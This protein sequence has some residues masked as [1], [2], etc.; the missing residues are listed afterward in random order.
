MKFRRKPKNAGAHLQL[1][2]MEY[3]VETVDK[4]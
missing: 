4:F 2:Q 1:S 3:F